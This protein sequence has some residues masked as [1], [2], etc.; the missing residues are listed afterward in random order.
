MRLAGC[1]GRRCMTFL[2]IGMRFMPIEPGRVH[3]TH[4]C[5]GPLARAQRAGKQPVVASDGNHRVIPRM[6]Q[7][8]E[9]FYRW[10]PLYGVALGAS[11][12]S[13]EPTAR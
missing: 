7:E 10:H 13:N 6:S 5:S 11:T 1:V 2:K 4:D 9:V 3:Q 12:A 8:V